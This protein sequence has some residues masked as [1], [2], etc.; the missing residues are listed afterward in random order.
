MRAGCW[1]QSEKRGQEA[2][3]APFAS[4]L[5]HREAWGLSL[6]PGLLPIGCHKAGGG[7]CFALL[8]ELPPP[9][10][11]SADPPPAWSIMGNIFS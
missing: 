4:A 7:I 3:S 1:G 6:S 8:E 5:L 11:W 9:G 10:L 2:E